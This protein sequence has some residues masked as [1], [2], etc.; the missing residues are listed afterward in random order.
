MPIFVISPLVPRQSGIAVTDDAYIS[1]GLH[2]MSASSELA[3]LAT[4]FRKPGMHAY[5]RSQQQLYILGE[6]LVTWAT[7]SE[8]TVAKAVLN[9][10][11]GQY[12]RRTSSSTVPLTG[13]YG[14]AMI[15]NVLDFGVDNT[16]V[17]DASWPIN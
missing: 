17:N 15:L 1:G 4:E 3:S 10:N 8:G 7:S 16:G 14:G 12:M 13:A 6:D 2:I 5:V 11:V 9:A